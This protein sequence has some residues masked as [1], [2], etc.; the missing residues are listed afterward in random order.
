M[1]NKVDFSPLGKVSQRKPC[2]LNGTLK[3]LPKL[4]GGKSSAKSHQ[5]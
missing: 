3:K 5:I 1:F 4:L 2:S